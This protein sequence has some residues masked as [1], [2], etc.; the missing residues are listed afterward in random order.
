[1]VIVLKAINNHVINYLFSLNPFTAIEDFWWR[2]KIDLNQD[3]LES[4]KSNM[5]TK[6]FNVHTIERRY[7]SCSLAVV[8][9]QKRNALVSYE[10]VCECGCPKIAFA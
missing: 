10:L 2:K 1:M 8:Y 3:F 6:F 5:K 7:G 4:Q 9:S